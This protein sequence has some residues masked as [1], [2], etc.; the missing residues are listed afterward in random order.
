MNKFMLLIMLSLSFLNA[1][2]NIWSKDTPSI[3]ASKSDSIIKEYNQEK[4]QKLNFEDDVGAKNYKYNY[5]KSVLIV[6]L[7]VGTINYQETIKDD[8][9]TQKNSYKSTNAKI[10]VGKDF[11]FF[12]KEY[13]QPTRIFFTY[14]FERLEEN[15]EFTIW[16]LG[17]REN[18]EYWSF[19]Q[20]TKARLY[21][22]ISLEVGKAN[23]QKLYYDISGISS[24]INLGTTYAYGDNFEYFVNLS[25]NYMALVNKYHDHKLD[26]ITGFGLNIGL[27]YKIMYDD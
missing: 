14:A 7:G 18:M 26:R 20:T 25:Y 22:T 13:T 12:H 15:Q 4:N 2:D 6:G 9:T 27:T 16:T 11:T 17:I 8:Y 24:Q 5:K 10:T 21:P 23:F 1:T 3:S 19:Y